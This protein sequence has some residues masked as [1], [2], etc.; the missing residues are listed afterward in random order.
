MIVIKANGVTDVRRLRKLADTLDAADI[1][2]L[3]APTRAETKE[4]SVDSEPGPRITPRTR[5]AILALQPV[6][7]GVP[8]DYET[9]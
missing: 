9:P 3:P 7:A 5:A 4:P 8:G 2:E 1:P 6:E